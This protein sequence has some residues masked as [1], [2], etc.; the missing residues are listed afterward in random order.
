MNS[1]MKIEPLGTPHYNKKD[2][3][4]Y[5]AGMGLVTPDAVKKARANLS[6]PKMK[7]TYVLSPLAMKEAA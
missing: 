5:I 4:T 3:K 6:N 2:D 1:L 7:L